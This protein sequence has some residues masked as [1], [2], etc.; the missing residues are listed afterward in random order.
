DDGYFV[1]V[2]KPGDHTLTLQM[3]VPVEGEP[4]KSERG[5][6]LGLPRAAFTSLEQFD[7]PA[8]VA[9]LRIPGHPATPAKQLHSKSASPRPVALG[10]LKSLKLPGK[11]AAPQQQAPPL[12]NADGQIK[13]EIDD[14]QIT[15]E[16]DLTLQSSRPADQWRIHLPPYAKPQDVRVEAKEGR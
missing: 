4:G 9:E 5:F 13:V 7:L 16:A 6:E 8:Q 10:A 1:L 11:G 15:T 12:L 3:D 14:A 2:E